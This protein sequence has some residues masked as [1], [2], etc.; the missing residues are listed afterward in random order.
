VK[1]GASLKR[2]M[3]LNIGDMP[4]SNGFEV[5]WFNVDAKDKPVSENV[6]R[7]FSYEKYS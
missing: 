2:N 4:G 3:K 1:V 5:Q 6:I 7:E